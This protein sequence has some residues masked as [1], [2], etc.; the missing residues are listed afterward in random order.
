MWQC[1]QVLQFDLYQQKYQQYAKVLHDFGYF[2][3]IRRLLLMVGGSVKQHSYKAD[4]E[5]FL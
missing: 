1:F 3:K 5:L 4:L 2:R